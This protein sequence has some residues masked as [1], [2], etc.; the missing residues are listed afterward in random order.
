MTDN[1]VRTQQINI[2][3]TD[4]GASVAEAHILGIGA[5]AKS[6]GRDVDALN[7]ILGKGANTNSLSQA[8]AA[9]DKVTLS[10]EKETAAYLKQE[11]ALNAAIVQE[12]RAAKASADLAI[13]KN[14]ITISNNEVQIS[15]LKV[16][17]A[18]N[19]AVRSE[20]R[21]KIASAELARTVDDQAISYLKVETALNNAVRAETQAEL[22][23]VRLTAANDRQAAA[24]QR[25]ADAEARKAAEA[26]AS[27]AA[28][29][30]S[31]TQGGGLGSSGVRRPGFTGGPG[32]DPRPI[33]QAA[34]NVDRLGRN[35]RLA[36]HEMINLG[37]QVQDIFVSLAG[38]QN[39]F[40][41]LLQ[42]GSQIQSIYGGR[43]E[44]V[45]NAFKDIGAILL[46]FVNPFTVIT[47]AVVGAGLAAKSFASDMRD[48]A[49][50]A[51]RLGTNTDAV[52]ELGRALT[53]LSNGQLGFDNL[54]T[55]VRD[56]GVA[57][58]DAARNADSQFARLWKSNGLS[59]KDQ[60]GKL[61][62]IN[63]LL[64]DA[65]RLIA[66]AGSEF[67]K[68]SIAHILGLSDDWIKVL[69]KGPTALKNAEQAA[70]DS[71]TTIDKE[72]VQ[73]AA[74][75]DKA[76]DEGWQKFRT[77]AGNVITEVK[78]ALFTLFSD[79][80]TMSSEDFNK[81]LFGQTAG[82]ASDQQL[83]ALMT[84]H[85]GAAGGRSLFQVLA[86]WAKDNNRP[87][88][89]LP[90]SADD[91]MADRRQTLNDN[92]MIAAQRA[93]FSGNNGGGIPNRP[94]AGANDNAPIIPTGSSAYP[95]I[96]GMDRL[97]GGGDTIV[98][99]TAKPKEDKTAEKRAD[100]L[101]KVNRELDAQLKLFGMIGPERE[102]Q[103]KYD[104][105]E[106][107]LLQKKITLDATEK[108]GIKDKIALIVE[109]SRIQERL[110]AIYNETAGA[111]ENYNA[112]LAAANKLLQDGVINQKQ[113]SKAVGEARIAV[114]EQSDDAMDGI[115]LGFLRIQQN[116]GTLADAVGNSLVGAV[117]TAGDALTEFFSTGKLESADFTSAIIGDIAR[118]VIQ[119]KIIAP[120]L[121]SLG[122][123][124][125]GG[126]GFTDQLGNSVPTSFYN[127]PASGSSGGGGIGSIL[128]SAWDWLSSGLGFAGGGSFIVGGGGG[129]DK[130]P[131]AFSAT[132]GER[133][134]VE[135]PAQQMR[136]AASATAVI[137]GPPVS[138]NIDNS[139]ANGVSVEPGQQ[140]R[141]PDGTWAIDLIVKRTK[142]ELA[143]DMAKGGTPI[144]N[145]TSG[146]FAIN[147][148]AGNRS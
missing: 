67:D 145:A 126:S 85:A 38:G 139:G 138:I 13:A 105:I 8:A 42:Q 37:Y 119:Y 17:Q 134:T 22:A 70:K 72:L 35:T 109:Q 6:A 47:A 108:E 69:E 120:L 79:I 20:T 28:A 1:A 34:D 123:G 87:I 128:S 32:I 111:Q 12:A 115:E 7:K 86:D 77:N 25:A 3:I 95:A 106:N 15:Y 132:R 94:D 36:N 143:N 101:A 136:Q 92:R 64:L 48:V 104:D 125:S 131:V 144:A 127:D 54:K 59:L 122:I 117:N 56:F 27:A 78:G 65:S 44:S 146:R 51:K 9:H 147:Q 107:S 74:D 100:A 31:I 29:A 2:V 39:P 121:Q 71:G 52:Q 113:W 4:K 40:L 142:N 26:A 45:L 75:F 49:E 116:T 135:T 110:D 97:P 141:Q 148:A 58:A 140:Q 82:S 91:P 18:L 24:A 68:V 130:T 102:K 133:V 137:S 83:A 112:T 53:Q 99:T 11:N 62:D 63:V 41:V 21:A 84:G 66:N 43:G 96:P 33:G 129:T 5:A 55:D 57:A 19:D 14:K 50:T 80:P 16:E 103:Q 114:L 30:R 23:T 73:R 46:R 61:K 90:A 89:T 76:W 60:N 98:P 118:L 93:L 81:A 10:L 124:P 88:G